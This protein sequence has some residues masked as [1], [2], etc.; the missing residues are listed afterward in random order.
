MKEPIT[1]YGVTYYPDGRKLTTSDKIIISSV[2]GFWTLLNT[3][4]NIGTMCAFDNR[5]EAIE[6]YQKRGYTFTDV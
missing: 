1:M 5:E 6:Y 3:Y 2:H 4:T